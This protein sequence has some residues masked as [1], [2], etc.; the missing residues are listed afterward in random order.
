[1]GMEWACPFQ[2]LSSDCCMS[3]VIEQTLGMLC[4]GVY[5][6]ILL[7]TPITVNILWAVV[8]I[9]LFYFISPLFHFSLILSGSSYD[10]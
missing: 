5:T 6:C 10:S 3:T 2:Q 1:M 8:A 7:K 4:F 9:I